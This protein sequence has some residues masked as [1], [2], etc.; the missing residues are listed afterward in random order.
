MNDYIHALHSRLDGHLI[1]D[2]ANQNFH[3]LRKHARFRGINRKGTN[4][5]SCLIQSMNDTWTNSTGRTG[6][7]NFTFHITLHYD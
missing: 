6:N 1:S 4:L 5:T 7:E 2:I 3:A